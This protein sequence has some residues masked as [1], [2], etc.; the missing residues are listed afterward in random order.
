MGK[1]NEIYKL[2]QITKQDQELGE[3]IDSYVAALDT[4]SKMGNYGLLLN[5]IIRDRNV[6]RIWG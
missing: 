6:V 4:L 5:S 3:S 2:Y 1:T